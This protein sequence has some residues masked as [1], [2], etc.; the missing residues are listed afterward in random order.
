[1]SD[2]PDPDR[3]TSPVGYV[4]YNVDDAEREAISAIASESSPM[5]RVLYHLSMRCLAIHE[6]QKEA[7]KEYA[8][9]KKDRAEMRQTVREL[10][11]RLDE[12]ER[13]ARLQANGGE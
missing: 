1:M 2:F 13:S 9:A 6:G 8:A 12:I 3:D 7:A 10:T 11:E 4:P 5:A